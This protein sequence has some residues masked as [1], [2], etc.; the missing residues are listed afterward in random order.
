[1]TLV[2]LFVAVFVG[3]VLIQKA[4]RA[5]YWEAQSESWAIGADIHN[6]FIAGCYGDETGPGPEPRYPHWTD[7][8]I[9]WFVF[10][11]W[12][13]HPYPRRTAI[14]RALRD[15]RWHLRHLINRHSY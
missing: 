14:Y 4:M 12:A 1:M 13:I 8:Q 11:N 7:P 2:L 15:W 5:V 3:L 6:E 9:L 10:L